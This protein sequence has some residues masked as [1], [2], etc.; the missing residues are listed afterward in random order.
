[1]ARNWLAL[2]CVPALTSACLVTDKPDLEPATTTRPQ[3]IENQP[4]T[5]EFI[6]KDYAESINLTADVI[7]EDAGQELTVVLLI[8]YGLKGIGGDP[9]QDYS[10][11]SRLTAGSLS[12]GPRP[13]TASVRKAIAPG[14]HTLT[15][16]VTHA[17]VGDPPFYWCP[18]NPNDH[19]TL[20]WFLSV[21]DQGNCDF[22]CPF[23]DGTFTYCPSN[24]ETTA[25]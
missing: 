14:C 17:I 12:D 16:L 20:T 24:A 21:C 19:D 1:L 18:A 13:I 25:P 22:D 23:D 5:T 3:L 6:Q 10:E 7:S 2:L 9:W 11:Q 15:L 4:R 8:D